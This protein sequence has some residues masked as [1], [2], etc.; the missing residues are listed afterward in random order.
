MDA[1]S[2][3]E[4][5]KKSGTPVAAPKTPPTASSKFFGLNSD[6]E[7]EEENDVDARKKLIDQEIQL[8][9]TEKQ[10]KF[11]NSGTLEENDPLEW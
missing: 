11:T 10:I 1:S 9:L 2:P 6:P 3:P 8:W 7:E 5:Q 4:N